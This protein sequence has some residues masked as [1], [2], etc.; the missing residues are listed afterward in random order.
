M[1]CGLCPYT[2]VDDV[3]LDTLS[4]PTFIIATSYDKL[5]FTHSLWTAVF[6]AQKNKGKFVAK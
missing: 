5:Q 2:A 4:A 6:A 3:T 1:S